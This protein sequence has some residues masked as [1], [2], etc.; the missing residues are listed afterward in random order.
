M[1]I[2]SVHNTTFSD[3]STNLKLFALNPIISC[4]NL[5]S[6]FTILKTR[7]HFKIDCIIFVKI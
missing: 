2:K 1:V 6:V 4:S 5:T 7:L 3:I